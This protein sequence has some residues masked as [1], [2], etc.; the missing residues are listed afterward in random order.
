MKA[1]LIARKTIREMWREPLLFG[2]FLFFPA[3]FIPLYYVAYGQPNGGLGQMLR[4]LVINQDAGPAGAELVEALRGAQFDGKPVLTLEVLAARS[5]A[6]TALRER[7]AAMLL[8]IPA[9]FTQA[10]ARSAQ[11]AAPVDLDMV[12]DPQSDYYVFA[13]SF[14]SGILEEFTSQA[15]GWQGPPAAMYEFVPGTGTMSDLQFGIPGLFVFGATFTVFIAATLLV[16]EEARGTLPRLRLTR[17]RGGDVILGVTLGQMAGAVVQI[18]ITFAV[19]FAFGFRT[20][21]SLPLAIGIG[22]LV[23]LAGTGLG[24]VTACF[25]HTDGE[26]VGLSTLFLAPLAFLSGAIFPMPAAPI[27]TLAGHTVNLYDILPTT[28][29]A[30]AMRRVLIFGDGPAEIAYELV[31]LTVLSLVILGAGAVLYQRRRLQRR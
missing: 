25:T 17:A 9:G 21:G 19:A 13:G 15:T 28:S 18:L 24:L 4:V 27:G 20:P 1:L 26:A 23:T 11:G 22:L 16:R 3:M 5:E 30:E 29:A 14:V 2:I 10:L 12:G 31:V 7:K 6:E 8:V